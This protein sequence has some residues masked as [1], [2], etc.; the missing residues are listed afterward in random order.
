MITMMQ[1]ATS[2]NVLTLGSIAVFGIA[3]CAVLCA[4]EYGW[5][6]MREL[7]SHERLAAATASA[8]MGAS[9]FARLCIPHARLPR[10]EEVPMVAIHLMAALSNGIMAFR[11]R[12]PVV[13]DAVTGADQQLVRMAE[14]FVL[15]FTVTYLVEAL[16]VKNWKDPLPYA[17][18]IC[19]STGTGLVLPFVAQVPSWLIIAVSSLIPYMYITYKCW[20]DLVAMDARSF[21]IVGV[22]MN[23]GIREQARRRLAIVYC[24]VYGV[25]ILNYV[26]TALYSLATHRMPTWSFPVDCAWDIVAKQVYSTVIFNEDRRVLTEMR[27]YEHV[28]NTIEN[29]VHE[30]AMCIVRGGEKDNTDKMCLQALPIYR[31]LQKYAGLNDRIV[32]ECDDPDLVVIADSR[33][34]FYV[35]HQIVRDLYE[36]TT[37]TL[38]TRIDYDEATGFVAIRVSVHDSDHTVVIKPIHHVI[39]CV[40]AM[41]EGLWNIIEGDEA[42]FTFSFKA[43]R[44]THPVLLEASQ[45][46][47][48]REMLYAVFVH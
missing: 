43:E 12:L 47:W 35:H 29:H 20:L 25:F 6:P 39:S 28:C 15:S 44:C 32:V 24:F 9:T 21:G 34:V 23:S 26:A 2:Y 4:G 19:M 27:R 17:I 13:P 14:W 46:P 41:P 38:K 48:L 30:L 1:W 22:D 10:N 40:L 31:M 7:D 37:H 3:M 11:S 42:A 36:T 5:V 18:A 16:N 45:R 33:L 8:F